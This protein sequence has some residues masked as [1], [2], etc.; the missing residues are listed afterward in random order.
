[1]LI[2]TLGVGVIGAIIGGVVGAVPR[3]QPCDSSGFGPDLFCGGSR[4]EWAGVFALALGLVALVVGLA[5]SLALVVGSWALERMRHR[6]GPS[7]P[8]WVLL[9]GSA[10]SG[11][12]VIAAGVGMY[13]GVGRLITPASRCPTG[14]QPT[15]VLVAK[16]LIPKGTRGP[17][18]ASKSLYAAEVI[19][20]REAAQGAISDP[21][22]L[23]VR[24][25]ATDIFPGSQLTS[26]DF[27][28]A[29]P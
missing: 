20:C 27:R 9:V 8:P 1:V 29:Q 25:A 4:A 21:A 10:F 6:E 3:V 17:T 28:R 11:V 23:A 15:P 14:A 16:V 18:I 22:D 5:G 19:P 26:A 12:V 13:E 24:V 2:G 7:L